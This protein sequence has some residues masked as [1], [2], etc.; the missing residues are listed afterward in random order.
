MVRVGECS[1][2]ISGQAKCPHC[3]GKTPRRPLGQ[4]AWWRRGE[5]AALEQVRI[6]R[7]PLG[8]PGPQRTRTRLGA[9]AGTGYSWSGRPAGAAGRQQAHSEHGEHR[10]EEH[11]WH[12]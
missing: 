2:A 5:V 8:Q 12:A 7:R 1:H 6:P 3:P 9:A 11:E 4:P 10:V